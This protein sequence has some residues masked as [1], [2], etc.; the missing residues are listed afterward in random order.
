MLWGTRTA[1]I[2]Q[3]AETVA[4][5]TLFKRKRDGGDDEDEDGSYRQFNGS[6]IQTSSFLQTLMTNGRSNMHEKNYGS[7]SRHLH[8]IWELD[9]L[10]VS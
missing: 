10:C 3:Y 8:I 6:F 2:Y 7:P 4:T 1:K 5:K 9:I